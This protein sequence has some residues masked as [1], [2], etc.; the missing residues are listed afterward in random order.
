M[1]GPA[2][3]LALTWAVAVAAVCTMQESLPKLPQG[4]NTYLT[5][6][7]P[8]LSLG[9][10]NQRADFQ[11]DVPPPHGKRLVSAKRGRR[12]AQSG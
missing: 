5:F 4:G 12:C 8:Y 2:G 1:L 6:T 7:L 3:M 11:R 9:Q 10:R